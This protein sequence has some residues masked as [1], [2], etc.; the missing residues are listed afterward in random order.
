MY[1]FCNTKAEVGSIAIKMKNK[2]FDTKALHGGMEQKDRLEVIQ[3]FKRGR[4]PFLVATDVAARGIDIEEIT[5]VINY[6]VP[7]EKEVM[8][9]DW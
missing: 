2:G 8:F 5:H 9:T 1:Y 6:E 7:A 4:F 3:E